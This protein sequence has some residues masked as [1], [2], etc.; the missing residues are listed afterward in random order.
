MHIQ[1]QKVKMQSVCFFSQLK[2]F[3][4]YKLYPWELVSPMRVHLKFDS[5]PFQALGT[6]AFTCA[7]TIMVDIQIGEGRDES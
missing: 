1:T 4:L 5:L 2:I 6:L 3:I 7:V